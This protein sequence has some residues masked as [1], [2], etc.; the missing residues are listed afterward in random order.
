MENI[1]CVM[2]S[3]DDN[4]D[5]YQQLI[6]QKVMLIDRKI[7]S[8]ALRVIATYNIQSSVHLSTKQNLYFASLELS[9]T[10]QF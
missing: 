9:I 3:N 8:Y 6:D 5:N 2:N 1:I 10:W 7:P 4:Y